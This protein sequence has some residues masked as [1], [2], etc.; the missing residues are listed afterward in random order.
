MNVQQMKGKTRQKH[1]LI[2]S[3]KDGVLRRNTGQEYLNIIYAHET[4]RNKGT[5]QYFH[6]QSGVKS[7]KEGFNKITANY[8][9]PA[10]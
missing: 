2:L 10:R 9:I 6:T 1:N 4:V 5:I 3:T 7:K 8:S